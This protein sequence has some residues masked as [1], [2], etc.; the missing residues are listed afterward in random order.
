MKVNT[1]MLVTEYSKIG[2]KYKNDL[3]E[4]TWRSQESFVY[5]QGKYELHICNVNKK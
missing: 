3:C 1:M 2:I 4:K 5:L